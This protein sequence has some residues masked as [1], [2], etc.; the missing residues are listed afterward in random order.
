MRRVRFCADL[1]DR[2][3]VILAKQSSGQ[4]RRARVVVVDNLSRQPNR[5]RYASAKAMAAAARL[6][7]MNATNPKP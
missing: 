2:G 3:G 6:P 7:R 1:S 4:F 5:R